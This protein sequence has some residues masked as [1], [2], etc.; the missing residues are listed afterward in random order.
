MNENEP[1]K[2]YTQQGTKTLQP[3]DLNKQKQT[4]WFPSWLI[5]VHNV[6]HQDRLLQDLLSFVF[7]IF[8][9]GSHIFMSDT[10]KCS[11]WILVPHRRLELL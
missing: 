1:T 8:A 4:S 2:D 3:S 10:S 5:A 7:F 6:T 11:V 9:S